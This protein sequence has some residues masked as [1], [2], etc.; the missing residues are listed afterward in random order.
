MPS[1]ATKQKPRSQQQISLEKKQGS[2]QNPQVI[3]TQV[4]SG[5]PVGISEPWSLTHHSEPLGADH[6]L[7]LVGGEEQLPG[8]G[9]DFKRLAPRL[10]PTGSWTKHRRK[11][12][13]IKEVQ[14]G[15]ELI[16]FFFFLLDYLDI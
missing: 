1:Q 8:G 16:F 3:R 7:L 4:G 10:K 14:P 6:H 9:F 11:R 13:N 12:E 2:S 15:P 5:W